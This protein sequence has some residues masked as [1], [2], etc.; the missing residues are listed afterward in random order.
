MEQKFKL[1]EKTLRKEY[2]KLVKRYN[3]LH[4]ENILLQTKCQSLENELNE[5]KKKE[6]EIF[7]LPPFWAYP[8][9][10]AILNESEK[11]SEDYE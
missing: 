10:T 11:E 8:L 4:V 1:D 7:D 3:E 9:L 2:C 5:L 6:I